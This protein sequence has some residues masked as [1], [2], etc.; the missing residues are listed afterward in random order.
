MGINNFFKVAAMIA[1]VAQMVVAQ[2]EIWDGTT[3]IIWYNNNVDKDTFF[4]SNGRE[5]AGLAQLVN[6]PINDFANKTIILTNNIDLG[7]RNWTPIGNDVRQ[8]RG[9]FDGNRHS[10]SNLLIP[11][12][13]FAGLF[14]YVGI[15]GQ[16]KNLVVNVSSINNATYAGG[17][18]GYYASNKEIVNGVVNISNVI[19][20]QYS[21]GIAGYASETITINNS[22]VKG[23]VFA[24][25]SLNFHY[26]SPP[27]L[28]TPS[29]GLSFTGVKSDSCYSGGLVGYAK[30]AIT[31]NNS[32]AV[33]DVSASISVVSRASF[34]NF[35]F[36]STTSLGHFTHTV[37][38][39]AFVNVYL[40]GLV[41]YARQSIVIDNSY[42]TS[43]I[44]VSSTSQMQGEEYFSVTCNYICFANS[45]YHSRTGG[46]LGAGNNTITINNS[47]ATSNFTFSEIVT[48]QSNRGNL[49]PLNYIGGLVGYTN[50][51]AN[52]ANSYA[53]KVITG[54]G[55]GTNHRGGIFGHWQSGTNTSVYYN[56]AGANRAAGIGSP[57]GVLGINSEQL[58]KQANFRGWDFDYIWAI[59]ED[60]SFPYLIEWKWLT[61]VG[62]LGL[63]E[64][65]EYIGNSIKPELKVRLK[66]DGTIL[67]DGVDYI[68]SYDENKNVSDG[69][70]ILIVG[71]GDYYGV[72]SE[73]INF[74]ITPRDLIVVEATAQSKVYD[75]TI[76]ARITI[77]GIDGIIGNDN[78]SV[79]DTIGI[80]A[81]KNVGTAKAVGATL[82]LGGADAENYS[83]IQ[84]TGLTANITRRPLVISL[85]PKIYNITLYDEVPN[86]AENLDFMSFATGDTRDVIT[87]NININH[88]Y[89]K[90]ISPAETYTI[91]LSGVLAAA[92]YDISYDNEGLLLIVSDG[93][94][95][96]HSVEKF[97]RNHG[98]KF[99][100]NP[101]SEK[102]EIR[103]ILPNNEIVVETKIAI[104]D[105]VGNVVLETAQRSDSISWGLTNSAG[106][107]VANG[108]YLVV[109]EVRGM[110]GKIYAYSAR[111]GIKR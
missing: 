24:S 8:F 30:E 58:K 67:N 4:I 64:Q 43:N 18:V 39:N 78:V 62:I 75:G 63:D 65:Y 54:G 1:I 85:Y 25:T 87:G 79:E 9:I 72:I 6:N 86:F 81:D 48:F 88:S 32:Y 83:L 50:S 45:Y 96:I 34:G 28:W 108:V 60:V 104:Y 77:T 93:T 80:F 3:D 70:T 95:S 36:N 10:I 56:S 42:A 53:S 49:R 37:Y 38:A 14:G 71:M 76:F 74:E 16:I 59:D 92:N 20:G 69:G 73:I 66:I 101:V 33:S 27:I 98:I 21:G 22:Y 89:Q 61:S 46:L 31:I 103:I 106:R 100:L 109:A 5:L 15:D 41:G 13:N 97:D 40:G 29:T 11:S 47:Y 12:G 26:T 107:N 57:A 55:S 94:T 2:T 110:S 105:N 68:I 111:L 99:A 84:P 19:E 82:T 91:R 51:N 44:S 90:G 17:L 23:N 7:D 102:A 52:I 35:C